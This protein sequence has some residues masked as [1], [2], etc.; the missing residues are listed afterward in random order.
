MKTEET[1]KGEIGF[2]NRL[3]NKNQSP[4]IKLSAK[5]RRVAEGRIGAIE[6]VLED[7]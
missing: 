4:D 7:D 5:Q 6:W 3:L 2:L 1:L